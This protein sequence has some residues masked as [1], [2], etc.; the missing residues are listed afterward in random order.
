MSTQIS[1]YTEKE[2]ILRDLAF[3]KELKDNT[4][5]IDVEFNYLQLD[6]DYDSIYSN[7]EIMGVT[8]DLNE[9]NKEILSKFIV[10]FEAYDRLIDLQYNSGKS[11]GQTDLISIIDFIEEIS[12][13]RI[14]YDKENEYFSY[15]T[16]DFDDD[17]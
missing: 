10:D 7:G 1:Q 8:V 13:D 6:I 9:H 15:K 4:L 2:K 11:E 3:T 14:Y 12:N 17:Y 5:V 16:P